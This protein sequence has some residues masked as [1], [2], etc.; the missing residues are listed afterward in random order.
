MKS[1]FLK[2]GPAA[3]AAGALL[4]TAAPRAHAGTDW[5]G[6]VHLLGGIKSLDNDWEP[7]E[8][9]RE[10][11]LQT[12]LRR[13]NWP[14]NLAIDYL[15]ASSASEEVD[16]PL[17]GTVSS[18]SQTQELRFGL[19]KYFERSSFWRPFV[20]G[21]LA[22]LR[23]ADKVTG[24]VATD[25]DSDYGVGF[26]ASAGLTYLYRDAVSVGGQLSYSTGDVDINQE[27][28]NAGGLHLSALVGL[29]Y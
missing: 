5:S 1:T 24:P 7:A 20:G 22:M 23:G 18:K 6:N 12:D 10:F 9:E 19:R 3:F 26:W 11:G 16:V 29:H 27:S 15:F 28:L 21:G 13:T 8:D 14:I 17:V 25:D 2:F 4:F